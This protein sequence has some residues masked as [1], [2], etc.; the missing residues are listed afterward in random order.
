[1]RGAPKGSRLTYEL[2]GKL[3]EF[4]FGK[5]EGLAVYLNGTELPDEV[6]RDC[7]VN[8]IYD[9]FTEL[10]GERGAIWGD[11]QGPTETALYL[12][13]DSYDDMKSLISGFLSEYPLCR[14]AR[15]IRIA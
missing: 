2:D 6:Y 5:V 15:V 4:A 9:R 7:D 1:M 3:R 10:L 12:Y 13:G 11:W 8:V 14:R